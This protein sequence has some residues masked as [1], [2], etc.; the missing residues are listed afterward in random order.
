[1]PRKNRGFKAIKNRWQEN[2]DQQIEEIA[3]ANI[4][5]TADDDYIDDDEIMA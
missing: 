2:S 4:S 5:E 1:M 3:T